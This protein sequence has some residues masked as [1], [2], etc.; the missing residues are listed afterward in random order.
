MSVQDPHFRQWWAAHHVATLGV[1][2]KMLHHP[3]AGDLTLDWD[4]LTA[5]TDPDQQLVIWTAEPGTPLPRRPAH[6]RLLGRRPPAGTSHRRLTTSSS[7]PAPPVAPADFPGGP[8][9][10]K[11]VR[12]SVPGRVP[13]SRFSSLF[14]PAVGRPV[15][16]VQ[17]TAPPARSRSVVDT[18]APT[19]TPGR[20][21]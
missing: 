10:R 2:T 21:W 11:G 13:S 20:R 19:P 8:G 14:I 5:S 1:G 7:R 9:Q 4:T 6:P 3:V 15:S 17:A 12:P 16:A 18:R